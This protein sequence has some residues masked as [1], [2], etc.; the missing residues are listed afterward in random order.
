MLGVSGN[1]RGD[2]ALLNAMG[3]QASALG[4]HELDRGTGAFAAAIGAE[5]GDSGTYPG[6]A[7]PY[8]SSNLGFADDENLRPLGS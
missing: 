3:F 4:N 1:G 8:L 5:S 7:F 2:I 6:A